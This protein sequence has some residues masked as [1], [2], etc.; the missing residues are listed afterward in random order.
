MSVPKGFSSLS[1]LGVRGTRLRMGKEG[2]ERSPFLSRPLKE[3]VS[4][5]VNPIDY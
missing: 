1:P 5:E 4:Q 2:P 3:L